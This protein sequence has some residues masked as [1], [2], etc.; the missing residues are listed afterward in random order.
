MGS[1]G[2]SSQYPDTVTIA[3]DDNLDVIGLHPYGH[4]RAT[5]EAFLWDATNV[6]GVA[7]HVICTEIGAPG[8]GMAYQD[9]LNYATKVP[10]T[11]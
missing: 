1:V 8:I 4:T 2:V 9:S 7:K 10:G 5:I 3:Q 11:S 6:E